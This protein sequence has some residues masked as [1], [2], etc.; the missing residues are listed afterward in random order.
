M[1]RESEPV[2]RHIVGS[3]KKVVGFDDYGH[4]ELE[5]KIRKGPNAGNHTVWVEPDLVRARVS[6]TV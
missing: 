2:F 6:R 1:R 4:V 3:Y 5:F